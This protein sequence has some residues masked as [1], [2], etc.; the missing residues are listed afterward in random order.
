MAVGG[1][2]L[3]FGVSLIA[4]GSALISLVSASWVVMGI[5]ISVAGAILAPIG[6]AA[7]TYGIGS[8]SRFALLGPRPRFL[9][10]WIVTLILLG[11]EAFFVVSII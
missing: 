8:D 4:L 2:F 3:V 5:D 10:Y 1:F 9:Y 11:V 6:G 7:L